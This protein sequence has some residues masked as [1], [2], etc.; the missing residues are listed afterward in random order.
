MTSIVP[1]CRSTRFQYC[2]VLGFELSHRRLQLL[3]GF[4]GRAIQRVTAGFRSDW[5]YASSHWSRFKAGNKRILGRQETEQSGPITSVC[6][7]ECLIMSGVVGK[8]AG[9]GLECSFSGRA[10]PQSDIA[11][12]ERTPRHN[13][14]HRISSKLPMGWWWQPACHPQV[15]LGGILT[16]SAQPGITK[17]RFSP[18][19]FALPGGG[20]HGQI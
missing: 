8:P 19:L 10:V 5:L 12:S 14:I 18:P 16:L 1:R 15:C 17:R 3:D 11:D 13:P 20:A 4:D 7:P 9:R 6:R 2:S